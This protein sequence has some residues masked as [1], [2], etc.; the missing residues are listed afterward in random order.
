MLPVLLGKLT[1]LQR[2]VAEMRYGLNDYQPHSYTQIA[3]A[4]GV[5]R[6]RAQQIMQQAEKALRRKLVAHGA[7]QGIPALQSVA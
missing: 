1:D 5:S 3:E 7:P 2:Q 6:Q 4:V